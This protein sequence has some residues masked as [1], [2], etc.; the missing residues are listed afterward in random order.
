MAVDAVLSE[1][2]SATDSRLQGKIQGIL[3]ISSQLPSAETPPSHCIQDVYQA[4]LSKPSYKEQG[5]NDCVS[6]N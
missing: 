6:E 2:L 5:I 4:Q 3:S 1:L